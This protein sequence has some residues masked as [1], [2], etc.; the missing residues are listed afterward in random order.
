MGNYLASDQLQFKLMKRASKQ[1]VF[2]KK[3]TIT[4]EYFMKRSS[5]FVSAFINEIQN[6]NRFKEEQPLTN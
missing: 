4:L 2:V 1:D 6:K 3:T 5:S